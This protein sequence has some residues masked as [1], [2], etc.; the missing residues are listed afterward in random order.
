[1]R[2]KTTEMKSISTR[3]QSLHH[4]YVITKYN[5]PVDLFLVCLFSYKSRRCW[6]NQSNTVPGP[7]IIWVR[8]HRDFVQ[9]KSANIAPFCIFLCWPRNLIRF[10]IVLKNLKHIFTEMKLR[11]LPP[12]FYIHVS[13][14][15]QLNCRSGEKDREL[16][17]SSSWRQFPALPSTPA[18]EPRVHRN[19]QHT[20]FQFGKLWIINGNN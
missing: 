20:N 12:N 8:N 6:S 15:S 1:M 16:P 14:N 19:D 7:G 3:P 4:L 5:E 17:L 10:H 9:E 18:V 11:G 2:F 13:E